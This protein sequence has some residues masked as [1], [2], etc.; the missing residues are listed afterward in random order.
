MERTSTLI[1]IPKK[2]RFKDESLASLTNMVVD[3]FRSNL[4]GIPSIDFLDRI[5]KILIKGMEFTVVVKLLGRN[6]GYGPLH[7]HISSL[8]KPTQPFRLMDVANRYY[9][10]RFLSRADYDAALS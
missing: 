3:S 10:I 9:L 8:W 2:V 7:N 6:I 1:A 4:N 5:N